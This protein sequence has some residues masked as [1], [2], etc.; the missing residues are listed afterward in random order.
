V[1][2]ECVIFRD[3]CTYD[4]YVWCVYVCTPLPLPPQ[5][6]VQLTGEDMRME[7]VSMDDIAEFVGRDDDMLD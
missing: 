5:A 2:I 7:T 1:L 3:V 4:V 6:S